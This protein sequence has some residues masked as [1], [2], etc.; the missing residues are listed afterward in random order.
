MAA[1]VTNLFWIYICIFYSLFKFKKFKRLLSLSINRAMMSGGEQEL[2]GTGPVSRLLALAA[3]CVCDERA[4]VRRAALALVH[5]SLVKQDS[6]M[7]D[8]NDLGVTIIIYLL[9]NG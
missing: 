6:P 8:P 4:A 1:V 5:R 2:N 3:R 7:P 9:S